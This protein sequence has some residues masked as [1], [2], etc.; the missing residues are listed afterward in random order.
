MAG[1][2]LL[3]VTRRVPPESVRGYGEAWGRLADAARGA[4]A[5]AW[6]FRSAADPALFIEFLEFKGTDDP[7]LRPDLARAVEEL[8]D[9][10]SGRMEEWLDTGDDN[11]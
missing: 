4:N 2:T 10:A 9:L 11:P 1:R 8:D 7:R 5:H 3:S 6:R